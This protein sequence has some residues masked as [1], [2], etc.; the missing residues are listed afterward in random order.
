[1]C[2][3]KNYHTCNLNLEGKRR[4]SGVKVNISKIMARNFLKLRE[5]SRHDS[6]PAVNSSKI[7]MKTIIQRH[8]RQNCFKKSRKK[9]L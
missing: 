6:S 1:M 5:E 7:K 4:E 8:I 2:R 9:Y 3:I